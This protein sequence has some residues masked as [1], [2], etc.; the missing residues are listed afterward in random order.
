MTNKNLTDEDV[1]ERAF[2]K[3]IILYIG[4]P[5]YENFDEEIL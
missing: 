1:A 5:N 3:A 2:Q 4:V